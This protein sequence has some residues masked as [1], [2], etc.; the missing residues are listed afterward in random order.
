MVVHIC[1]SNYSGDRSRVLMHLR[2]AQA[3][4]ARPYLKDKIQ[5]KGLGMWLSGI[6]LALP[7]MHKT[8]RLIPSFEKTKYNI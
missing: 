1:K 5:T 6:A 3:K 2:P 8:L 7:R 4:L